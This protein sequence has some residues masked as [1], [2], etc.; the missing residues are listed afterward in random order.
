MLE[1]FGYLCIMSIFMNFLFE[2]MMEYIQEDVKDYM[3]NEVGSAFV[4]YGQAKRVVLQGLFRK[5]NQAFR[6]RGITKPKGTA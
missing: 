5:H 2:V 6:D 4:P 1:S 3:A